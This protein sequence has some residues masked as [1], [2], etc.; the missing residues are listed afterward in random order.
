MNELLL[1][2]MEHAQGFYVRADGTQTNEVDEYKQALRIVKHLYGLTPAASFGP[3]ALKAVREEMVRKGWCRTL[4]NAR[5]GRVRR[6]WRWGASEEIVPGSVVVDLGTVAGLKK[7]R[8]PAR[9]TP[10]VKPAPERLYAATLPHLRPTPLAMVELQ[11]LSGPRPGEVRHLTPRDIDTTGDLWVYQPTEH[12]MSY[13]GRDKAVPLSPSARALLEVWFAGLS[14]DDLVFTPAR[15]RAELFDARRAARKTKVPA[16]QMNRRKPPP[17]LKKKVPPRFTTMGYAGMI[18]RACDAAFPLPAELGRRKVGRREGTPEEWWSRLT[19]A[20]K[21]AVK[22]WRLA[23]RWH[24]NQLR[25]SFGTEVREKF[26]L[27]VAQTLLDHAKADVTQVYAERVRKATEEAV[28]AMGQ[29]A[30]RAVRISVRA[31]RLR[32]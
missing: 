11:R 20:E 23:H 30:G 1:A 9:E 31:E 26:G 7:N 18:R 3:T 12:K 21:A 19:D 32:S 8:T 28:K 16:S 25:H 6:V 15:A 4:V 5:V 14:P 17:T 22:A 27:E 29:I 13:L 2:F 24:P 10:R